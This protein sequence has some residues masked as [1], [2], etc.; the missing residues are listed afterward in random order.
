MSSSL[1]FAF[2]LLLSVAACVSLLALKPTLAAS[3]LVAN[4]IL[5]IDSSSLTAYEE[6]SATG[7]QDARPDVRNRGVNIDGSLRAGAPLGWAIAGNPLGAPVSD[8]N[9]SGIRL[10]TG[11]YSINDVDMVLPNAG[12]MPFVIGRTYNARQDDSGSHFDSTQS[13]QGVNWFQTAQPEILLYDDPS[14]ADDDLIYLVY[15]ADRFV[16]FDRM[17]TSSVVFKGMNGAGGMM[18]Y[19]NGDDTYVYHDQNGNLVYFLGFGYGTASGQFWKQ[20]S[21]DGSETYVGDSS[22]ASGASSS[23]SSGRIAEAFDPAD[24]RYTFSYTTV[25]GASRL[26]EVKVETKTGGTWT[27]TPTGL[28]TVGKVEYDYYVDADSY[29]DDGDLKL[30]TI[31]TPLT[32][33]G[34]EDVRK[35]YYRYYEGAFNASTNP[36]H[37]HAL[38][39]FVDFEGARKYDWDQDSLLDEDYLTASNASLE[40][41]ASAYFEYDSSHRINEAWMNGEC[42]CSGTGNGTHFFEY[43]S[44]GSYSDGSGYDTAWMGRTVVKKPDGSYMTVYHDEAMQPLSRVI[45]DADPDNTSPVPD[46]WVTQVVRTSAGLV[47]DIHSP[48]NCTGYTHSDGTITSSTTVGVVTGFNRYDST[49]VYEG[50]VKDQTWRDGTSGTEYMDRTFDL[51]TASV[52][53]ASAETLYRP[54]ATAQYS[55]DEE[56][57][58]SKTGTGARKR[59]LTPVYHS[60]TLARANEEVEAPV[61]S[62]TNHGAGGSTGDKRNSYRDTSGRVTF[63]KD[64]LGVVSYSE[65]SNGQLTK[66]IRDA[67]TT[68]LSPP[69]GYS[70]SAGIDRETT[71]TYDAQG[72]PDTTT[73]DDGQVTKRYYSKLADGRLVSLTYADYEASPLKFYGPVSY[74]VTNHVGKAVASGTIALSGNSSTS[75]LTAHI[76]ETDDDPITAVDLGTIAS[77]TTSHYSDTGGTLEETRTYFA[78]P[79]SEP[80]TD[81]THYDPMLY[82]YDDSGRRWRIKEASGTVRRTVYDAIGRA[83]STW[84]GTND[85]TFS[86]GESSGTDDMVKISLTEYDSGN[87]DGNG[88]VTKRTAFVEDST[89]DQR[90]TEFT[91]D[92]HGRTLVVKNPVAPHSFTKFDNRGRQ[93]ATALYSSTASINTA[94]DDPETETT[95]RLALSVTKYNE[96]GRVFSVIRHKIDVSDG[97]SDD[98]LEASLTWYDAAGR[99]V[100]RDGEQLTKTLYDD[101]GRA[102]HQF[103]LASH[104]DTTYADNDDVAG[105]I[106]LVESQTTYDTD[107]GDVL[108][109]ATISRSHSDTDRGSGETEG[110]LDTNADSDALEYTAAD[111]DGRIQITAHW[112]DRFGRRTDTVNYGTHGGVDFD[113]DGL[114]VPA[115][116]DTALRT[117]YAFNDDGDLETI[118][119][120]KGIDKL[121]RNRRCRASDERSQQLRLVGQLRQS[122]RN[123]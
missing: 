16:E 31:T 24:R 48:A 40:G 116:S 84:I 79:A 18:E 27:G 53:I 65:Y 100:K 115:R 71:Y 118:T 10:S 25:G 66:S 114:A 111:L 67:N 63:S 122:V 62:T 61:V 11:T 46:R 86:G 121:S 19:D 74:T 58:T 37:V 85:S 20:V 54:H 5:E 70:T 108:M 76:D 78:I 42:G 105:D 17:G 99:V 3:P 87:D 68:S 80:G 94:T 2:G 107:N 117:T 88:Y 6:D 38:K 77:L 59:I 106:V 83:E 14:D 7:V 110:P 4:P 82:G 123:R 75:A 89:T 56:T 112:Y 50:F 22:S 101:L 32:D 28:A 15:G 49:T 109:E 96:A 41:Y 73:A 81:G 39:Y 29:G 35:K 43:E 113:R 47:S 44:N 64:G 1:K 13:Y 52:S 57:T 12:T 91:N 21:P 36:G 60:G 51:D 72:R 102:T 8:P 104:D 92:A 98:T 69:T 33:F 119:D 26:T 120:P 103:I 34:I 23:Y 30:V 95:N 55:Y 45:T 90:V 9:I 93:I 97:S